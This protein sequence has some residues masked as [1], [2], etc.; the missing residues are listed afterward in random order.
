M[1]HSLATAFE[2]GGWGMYCIA[3]VAMLAIAIIVERFIVLF[4]KVPSDKKAILGTLRGHLFKGDLARA[5]RFLADQKPTPLVSILKAGLL[6]VPKG[7][8]EVQAAMDEASLREIPQIEK[9]TGY[10]AMLSNAAT[11]WGLLG[12]V[13]GL[14]KCFAAVGQVNPADKA[15]ILSMGISEAMNCTAFGL[16]TAIP[17]LM[18][19]SFLQSRSQHLIEEIH[20]SAVGV[21]NMVMQNRDKL[22]MQLDGDLA[23]KE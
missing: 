19:Y 20:E 11:L 3:V 12:T 10:L 13:V 4:T 21:L 18:I 2:Q 8:V 7:E 5:I 9:R 23:A 1:L 17:A 22:N 16:G 15:T 6:A 14:I